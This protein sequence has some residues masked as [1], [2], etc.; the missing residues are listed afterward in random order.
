MLLRSMDVCLLVCVCS[1]GK[2]GKSDCSTMPVKCSA[3]HEIAY[4][5]DNVIFG[6]WRCWGGGVCVMCV[7]VVCLCSQVGLGCLVL[8]GYGAVVYPSPL[9]LTCGSPG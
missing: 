1:I 8:Q 5:I 3:V 2:R 7:T 9:S 6:L 4:G